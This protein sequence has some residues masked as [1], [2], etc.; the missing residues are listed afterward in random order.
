MTPNKAGFWLVTGLAV[1]LGSW[2]EA[3]A[4]TRSYAS[5]P[6]PGQSGEAAV[7]PTILGPKD[8]SLYKEIFGF[9]EAGQPAKADA[10]MRQLDDRLLV[11]H[12]LAM[13]YLG[14]T[15]KAS[16]PELREWLAAYADQPDAAKIYK[17][18]LNRKPPKDKAPRAPVGSELMG[19]GHGDPIAV[20]RP[21]VSIRAATPGA[22]AHAKQIEGLIRAGK[23][24]AAEQALYRPAGLRNDETSE[25]RFRIAHGAFLFGDPAKALALARNGI[26]QTRADVPLLDWV[27]GLAA[28]R[29]GD[30]AGAL[31]HFEIL[32]RSPRAGAWHNAAGGFWGARA[33]WKS[34][35]PEK[36]DGLMGQASAHPRTFYGQLAIRFLA[37]D[38][39]FDWRDPPL[40]AADIARLEAIPAGRR[41]MA[42]AAIDRVDAAKA[43]I[44]KLAAS[45][46]SLAPVLIGLASRLNLAA[47]QLRLARTLFASDSP[48]N[49]A[50]VYPVPHWEPEEGFMVDRALLF[51]LMRHESGFNV[52]A[53]SRAGA[54]GL[55]QLMPSTASVVAADRSLK[56]ANKQKLHDP[57][58]NIELGQRYIL[59]LIAEDR[60]GDNLLNVLAAYN[61]GPGRVKNWRREIGTEDP[62]MF[63]ESIPVRE[64]RLFVQ[65]VATSYWV[66]CDRLGIDAPSLDALV[67]NKDPAIGGVERRPKRVARNTL[68]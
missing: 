48:Y 16:W 21:P 26:A 66:Y 65:R 40:G 55:L 52:M 20:E 10:L 36:V 62:L 33:A 25:L 3:Q 15:S 51:A 22:K 1:A 57:D 18:A 2:P 34:R 32:A 12:V 47:V 58:T 13:R 29:L 39:P 35:R 59:R 54:R 67:Q 7:L 17:L 6:A 64:T 44:A 8:L 56:G 28:F 46:K 45:D 24:A 30:Y 53:Q 61:A 37:L 60:I 68:G 19:A 38:S 5:L 41:A 43:E 4:E 50:S 49:L 23:I 27:A 63:L 42:L 9:E 11:G 31:N 14:P